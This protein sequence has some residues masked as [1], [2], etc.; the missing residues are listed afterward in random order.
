MFTKPLSASVHLGDILHSSCCC[1]SVLMFV[2]TAIH[3][4]SKAESARLF[5]RLMLQ[6]NVAEYYQSEANTQ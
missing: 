1:K 6:K 5:C 3:K 2:L 4:F